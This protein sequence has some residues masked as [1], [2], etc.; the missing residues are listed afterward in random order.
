MTWH[1]THLQGCFIVTAFC[2]GAGRV[3]DV[4]HRDVSCRRTCTETR[5]KHLL[6]LQ[7]NVHKLLSLRATHSTEVTLRGVLAALRGPRTLSGNPLLRGALRTLHVSGVKHCF[8]NRSLESRSRGVS[9]GHGRARR[10]SDDAPARRGVRNATNAQN[11]PR[12]AGC[13]RQCASARA[14]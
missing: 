5:T 11:A 6:H 1:F 2:M 10:L 14:R 12:R 13:Q 4:A 8:S 7:G 9:H 3:R